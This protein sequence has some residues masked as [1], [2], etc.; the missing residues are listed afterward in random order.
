MEHELL[1]LSAFATDGHGGNPAGVWLGTVLPPADEM[2]RIA[3]DVGYSETAFNQRLDDHAWVTRYYTPRA[4]VS[5]CGHAT[6]ATAVALGRRHGP[7]TYRFPRSGG[8]CNMSA[9]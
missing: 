5:F 7:G 4:E 6:I 1:R 3:A 8:G 2:Q 9:R